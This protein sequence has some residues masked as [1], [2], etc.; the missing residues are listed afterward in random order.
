M[1]WQT[2]RNPAGSVVAS[3]FADTPDSTAR[4]PLPTDGNRRPSQV[5]PHYQIRPLQSQ[6]NE[7]AW[8]PGTYGP[9]DGI[10]SRREVWRCSA[11]RAPVRPGRLNQIGFVFRTAAT[12]R[13]YGQVRSS[14]IGFVLPFL[15]QLAHSKPHRGF[16]PPEFRPLFAPFCSTSSPKLA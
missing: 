10:G 6:S 15:S 12:G 14:E 16:V 11:L 8:T 3:W 2:G 5:R 9:R 4:R 7:G 1:R 13:R